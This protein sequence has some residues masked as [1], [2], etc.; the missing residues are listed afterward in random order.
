M[1]RASRPIL[2]IC[3]V[4]RDHHMEPAAVPSERRICDPIGAGVRFLW[5]RPGP[6]SA[7]RPQ[8]QRP[9]SAY[10]RRRLSLSTRR[11]VGVSPACNLVIG[12]ELAFSGVVAALTGGLDAH[13]TVTG[14]RLCSPLPHRTADGL[15]PAAG[16]ETI[17]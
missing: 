5:A 8:Y 17:T 10:R 16:W 2:G 4:I 3:K 13:P 15:I 11:G 12:A 1:L 9:H 14:D 6:V 7:N